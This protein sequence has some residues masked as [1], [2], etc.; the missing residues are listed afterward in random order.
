MAATALRLIPA[1]PRILATRPNSPGR[2][3]NCMAKSRIGVLL[4]DAGCEVEMSNA[5]KVTGPGGR[6]KRI[7]SHRLSEP[8]Y[9][10]RGVESRRSRFRFRRMFAVSKATGP[11]LV[12]FSFVPVIRIIDSNQPSWETDKV[13]RSV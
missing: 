8:E 2:W 9:E 10:Q 4:M 3:V 1:R 5:L 13:G 11:C 7:C 6:V 12:Q